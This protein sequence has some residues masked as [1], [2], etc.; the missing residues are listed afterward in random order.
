MGLE[1]TAVSG[2]LMDIVIPLELVQASLAS[3]QPGAIFT[4]LSGLQHIK[5][6]RL[7]ETGMQD[8]GYLDTDIESLPVINAGCLA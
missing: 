3:D 6:L 5:R 8:S 2:D 4:Q 1:V 7:P